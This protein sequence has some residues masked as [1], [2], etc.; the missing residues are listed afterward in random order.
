MSAST[1]N[2]AEVLGVD[3]LQLCWFSTQQAADRLFAPACE[4]GRLRAAEVRKCTSVLFLIRSANHH[5]DA[6]SPL[7]LLAFTF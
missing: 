2:H 3:E 4:H 6:V 1:H 5:P 7:Q